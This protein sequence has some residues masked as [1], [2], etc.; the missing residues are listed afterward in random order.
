MQYVASSPQPERQ[1]DSSSYPGARSQTPAT[2]HV[3]VPPPFPTYAERHRL[4]VHGF[5]PDPDIV[6]YLA[7]NQDTTSTCGLPGPYCGSGTSMEIAS[8]HGM[9]PA[10]LT[11][12]YSVEGWI[13][14]RGEIESSYRTYQWHDCPMFCLYLCCVPCSLAGSVRS[15]LKWIFERENER[16]QSQGLFW[17]FDAENDT[18]E[19][20]TPIRLLAALKVAPDIRAVFEQQNSTRR[21]LVGQIYSHIIMPSRHPS[22]SQKDQLS[23]NG[24]SLPVTTQGR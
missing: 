4:F 24:D 18:Q 8:L 3:Y 17:N 6:Y 21:R 22:E 20:N 2:Q 10:E 7:V 15:K 19:T 12:I 13:T 14:L 5:G 23:T 9:V 11:D 16:L 1:A